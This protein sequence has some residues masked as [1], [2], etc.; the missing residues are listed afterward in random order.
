MDDSESV[1]I[2]LPES[3]GD[4]V[5]AHVESERVAAVGSVSLEADGLA[6]LV[7]Q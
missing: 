2:V 4:D 3:P 1:G 6:G 5:V 7:D